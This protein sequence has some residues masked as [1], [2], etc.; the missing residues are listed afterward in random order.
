M[1]RYCSK[2]QLSKLYS[3]VSLKNNLMDWMEEDYYG[4]RTNAW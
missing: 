4:A 1:E 2:S 3:I